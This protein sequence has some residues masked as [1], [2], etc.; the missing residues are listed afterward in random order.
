MAI[1]SSA[2]MNQRPAK[3]ICIEPLQ[4]KSAAF[5]PLDSALSPKACRDPDAAR[6]VRATQRQLP[7]LGDRTGRI[8]GTPLSIM[9]FR[10]IIYNTFMTVLAQG[11]FGRRHGCPAAWENF[12]NAHSE[13]CRSGISEAT[14]RRTSIGRKRQFS[15]VT[16]RLRA[17]DARHHR[18]ALRLQLRWHRDRSTY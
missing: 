6:V 17:A 10:R 18:R 9:S 15:F 5:S 2:L 12:I 8:F 1:Q 7:Q 4:L 3:G 14:R 11:I 16:D 13:D